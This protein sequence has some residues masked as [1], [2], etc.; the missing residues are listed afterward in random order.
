[1]YCTRYV[2]L[3][4]MWNT[5]KGDLFMEMSLSI[6]KFSYVP[7]DYHVRGYAQS[8]ENLD[9]SLKLYDNIVDYLNRWYPSIFGYEIETMNTYEGD[10]RIEWIDLSDNCDKFIEYLQMCKTRIVVDKHDFHMLAD[11]L[12]V[13]CCG[14][15]IDFVPGKTTLK[16]FKVLIQQHFD[17]LIGFVERYEREYK[18]LPDHKLIMI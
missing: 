12:G 18:H 9:T 6:A 14:H 4:L 3:L 1:M 11:Q 5:V 2:D 10:E 17:S 8:P 16:E 13:Y 15:L 7:S